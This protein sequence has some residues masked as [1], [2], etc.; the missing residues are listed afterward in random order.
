MSLKTIALALPLCAF[1]AA[2]ALAAG[3]SP[4]TLDEVTA[5]PHAVVRVS[6]ENA[7][8]PTQRQVARLAG[9]SHEAAAPVRSY[10]IRE[11][12]QACAQGSTH[13]MV[14]FNELASTTQ[15]VAMVLPP[16]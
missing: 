6:C 8:W 15:D 3:G 13:V 16:R 7:M 5:V 10:I 11:G 4:P 14:V 9:Q 12:R 2:P 1:A